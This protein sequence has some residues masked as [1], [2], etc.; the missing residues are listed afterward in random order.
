MQPEPVTALEVGDLRNRQCI[1]GTLDT[2][3]EFGTVEVKAG[4]IAEGKDTCNT[5]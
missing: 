4:G 3:I 2:N 1:A 5:E